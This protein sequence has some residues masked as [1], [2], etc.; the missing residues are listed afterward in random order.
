MLNSL[1]FK[2]TFVS[3]GKTIEGDHTFQK[4][5]TSITGKNETGKSMR[6]EMIRYALFGA[7]A[8]RAESKTYKSLS[9]QINFTIGG[10]TYTLSRAGNKVSLK[11]G[12]DDLAA[13]TKSVN[14]AVVRL[15]GYDIEVFDVANACLQG[16]IEALSEKTPGDRKRMVDRTIGLDALDSVIDV[17]A[18]D[19]SAT[20]KALAMM[21]DQVLIRYEK[22]IKPDLSTEQTVEQ[23]EALMESLEKDLQRR[24]FL[25]GMIAAAYT[26]EP[27]VSTIVPTAGT[28]KELEAELAAHN[29]LRGAAAD[30]KHDLDKYNTAMKGLNGYDKHTVFNYIAGK[31]GDKWAVYNA[32]ISR[33]PNEVSYTQKDI[34]LL[35]AGNTILKRK[36]NLL[37]LSCPECGASIEVS[38]EDGKVITDDNFDWQ[39]Y[40]QV[41]NLLGQ[42]NASS[43]HKL[44][45]DLTAWSNWSSQTPVEKPDMAFMP[46]AEWMGSHID[47]LMELEAFDPAA[48]KAQIDKIEID[49]ITKNKL[50]M[51]QISIKKA[52]VAELARFNRETEAYNKYKS[53]LESNQKELDSFKHIEEYLAQT[54]AECQKLRLY[55]DAMIQYEARQE[56]QKEALQTISELEANLETLS[57]VKKALGELKPLVK[58]HLIPSLNHVASNLLVQMTGGER[59]VIKVDENFNIEVDGD[60]INTLSG[61]AKAVANL[62]VRIGL[63]TVLTNKVFSVFLADEIDAA[64]DDS[65]AEYTANCLRNLT[66]TIDQIILVSHKQPDAD[67]NIQL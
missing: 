12:T 37:D 57:R 22:P 35:I 7:K 30:I 29:Q 19:V 27:K 60:A 52:E 63:G 55:N 40:N 10:K 48:A 58:L 21:Q 15:L 24:N 41:S 32:Y 5:L 67:H 44:Q 65:R 2:V 20:K 3:N 42:P 16:E 1:R 25:Q 64:M 47:V 45:T 62:A 23:Y 56:S 51:N 61:S 59:R 39:K 34:D 43:L 14:E 46:G 36:E 50:L 18:N 8:L 31:Y 66:N 28:L 6:L 49:W 17:V 38:L 33:K 53:V 54:K 13:G 9:A 26:P 11:L 4:G